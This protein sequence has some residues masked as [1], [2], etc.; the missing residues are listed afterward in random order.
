VLNGRQLTDDETYYITAFL[1]NIERTGLS[2]QKKYPIQLLIFIAFCILATLSLLNIYFRKIIKNRLIN[3][4][5]FLI[6]SAFIIR[7]LFITASNV[8]LSQNYA[9]DQPIKFS[10]K[11]HVKE[12]KIKCIFCHNSPEYS[13]ESGIPS[14]NVCMICHN[15]IKSGTKTG[16][17]E[18]N[19]I[20]KSY[21]ENKP[22]EWIKIHN[23]P[24][25][26][27]FSHAIHVSVGKIE[28]KKCH[29]PIEEMNVTKQF[30]S[31]SMGWCV[32]CHRET[33]VQFAENKYYSRH[34]ELIED[35]KSG[36]ID[37]VTADK[38]GANDCQ[39]CHY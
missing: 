17:F 27:F 29:G 10:H 22:I 12:N 14:T 8:G 32:Q 33:E 7:T 1:Q 36:K 21:K 19:K 28:C 18:I 38:I 25:H 4:G 3:F 9:P 20:I 34:N 31:L 15:K 6:A 30:S 35:I 23:L 2:K 37:K 5:I 24:D 26:V 13:R 16:R 39:K 11:I